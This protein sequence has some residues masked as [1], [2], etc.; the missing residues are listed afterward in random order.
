MNGADHDAHLDPWCVVP[1][2]D[3]TWILFGFALEH[4]ATA[5][6]AWTSSSELLELDRAT[7]RGGT[8]SGRRYL[9]GRRFEAIDVGAEGEEAR[10]AFG[11]LIGDAFEH[12]AAIR[13][14]DRMW[15]ASRKVAR[16]LEVQPPVR[17]PADIQAFVAR[18]AA[19]YVRLREQRGR[20]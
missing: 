4:A 6:L 19:A 20:Q 15:L 7:G 2:A 1:L 9:L 10:L 12:A 17:R 13:E 5:G 11:L 14:V 8:R 3:G 18:H 16:H